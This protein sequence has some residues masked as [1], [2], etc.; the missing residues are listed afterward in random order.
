MLYFVSSIGGP[1]ASGCYNPT[2]YLV[3]GAIAYVRGIEPNA[4]SRWYCYV[5]PEYAGTI[6]FT[7]AFKYFFEPLYLRMLTLKYKWEDE[8][9]PEKYY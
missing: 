9:Y 5:I 6:C 3:N 1:Y 2:K 8:F 7:L 4:L